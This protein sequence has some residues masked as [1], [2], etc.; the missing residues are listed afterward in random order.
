[1]ALEKFDN[2]YYYPSYH[3]HLC[4][5]VPLLLYMELDGKQTKQH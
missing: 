2:Y 3:R 5:H 1:M 4:H